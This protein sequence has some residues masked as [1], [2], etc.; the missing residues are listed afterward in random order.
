MAHIMWDWDNTLAP[1]CYPGIGK[2]FPEARKALWMSYLY[3][4]ENIISTCRT[5]EELA[6]VRKTVADERLPI[7]HINENCPARIARWSKVGVDGDSRKIGADVYIDDR[8]ITWWTW[9][10]V[11]EYIR[12]A[13]LRNDLLCRHSPFEYA[14][15]YACCEHDWC[16]VVT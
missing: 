15:R 11:Y 13:P 1:D 6:L 7:S 14:S 4:H 9:D 5:G 2:L 10:D 8:N 12:K 16:E 3:G